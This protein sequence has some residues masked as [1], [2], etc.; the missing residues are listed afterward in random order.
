[1]G[2]RKRSRSRERIKLPIRTS[3]HSPYKEKSEES[4][5]HS[6]P[7]YKYY[8][9]QSR[10]KSSS[11][12]RSRYYGSKYSE[13]SRTKRSQYPM[14]IQRRNKVR[15]KSFESDENISPRRKYEKYMNYSEEQKESSRRSRER[16]TEDL[17]RK[18]VSTAKMDI[19]IPKYLVSYLIGKDDKNLKN[20]VKKSKCIIRL[21]YDVCYLKHS[22]KMWD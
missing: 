1:M 22:R 14:N 10:R 13:D 18:D 8:K 6:P 17:R 20:I 15:E 16:D 7:K 5:S 2:S 4:Y 9:K 12:S 11:R 3:S 19:V 21:D